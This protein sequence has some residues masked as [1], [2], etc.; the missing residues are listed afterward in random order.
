VDGDTG[1]ETGKNF[2]KRISTIQE[3]SQLYNG[4]KLIK[5]TY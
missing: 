1:V 4:E 2:A 3:L 5:M